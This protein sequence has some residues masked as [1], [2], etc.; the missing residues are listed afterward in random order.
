MKKFIMAYLVLGMM[1]AAH[2]EDLSIES[3][4][5]NDFYKNISYNLL[6]DDK[7]AESWYLDKMPKEFG[8]AFLYYTRT[9]KEIRL[10]F[11]SLMVHESGN[12]TSMKNVN[13]DGSIDYGPSQ[14][15]SNNMRNKQFQKWYR[16]KDESHITT[17]YCF[18]MVE[19]INFYWDLY[20]KHGDKYVFIAY[21]GGEKTVY[22]KKNGLKSNTSLMKKVNR[23]DK[24]VRSLIDKY[25]KE[26]AIYTKNVRN[27]HIEEITLLYEHPD[28]STNQSISNTN[29]STGK[30][31]P[32]LQVCLAIYPKKLKEID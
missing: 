10:A 29:S 3:L 28:L 19:T 16:P 25:S 2:S 18:Y 30:T 4:E 7:I 14:L 32:A 12:F 13:R 11:F 26:L 20:N 6:P 31:K 23:Y 27:K 17:K 5:S 24:N 22:Y 9:K 1:F 8:D 15:N 21:N